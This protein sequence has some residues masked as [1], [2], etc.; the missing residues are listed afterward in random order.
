MSDW[1]IGPNVSVSVLKETIKVLTRLN[2]T[3]RAYKKKGEGSLDFQDLKN[4][5]GN[6][7]P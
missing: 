2:M 5:F 7:W 3:L 4:M 6:L 1:K